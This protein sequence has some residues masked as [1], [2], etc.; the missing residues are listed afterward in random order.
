MASSPSSTP[1]RPRH[2]LS[3]AEALRRLFSHRA[4]PVKAPGNRLSGSIRKVTRSLLKEEGPGIELLKQRWNDL[5]GER[6]AKISEPTRLTKGKA[7]K[8]LHLDILP[9]AAPLFQHQGESLRRKIS[10]LI[11]GDLA[12]IKLNQ[13]GMPTKTGETRI[14][15]RILTLEER[16]EL[17]AQFMD[18]QN[19]QLKAALMKFG[20]SFIAQRPK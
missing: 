12:V 6:L 14:G 16:R 4:V 9:A 5:A 18:V 11:G 20:S 7:G 13:T 1:P 8:I 3:E 10:V 19:T 2:E 17:E 15:T